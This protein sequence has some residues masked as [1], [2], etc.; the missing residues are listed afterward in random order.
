MWDTI[1]SG[2]TNLFQRKFSAPK[3]LHLK[4]FF[5]LAH[6]AF[7]QGT[8]HVLITGKV[9]DFQTGQAGYKK[10]ECQTLPRQSKMALKFFL[11]L[12]IVC[13]LR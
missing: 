5:F 8:A 13:Q 3:T 7:G 11:P 12:K 6:L 2:S 1:A 9:H 4:Y 10:N